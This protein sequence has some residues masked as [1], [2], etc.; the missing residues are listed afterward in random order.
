MLQVK[1]NDID[2]IISDFAS[3]N[4]CKIILYRHLNVK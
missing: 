4:I 1:L 2:I 3:R